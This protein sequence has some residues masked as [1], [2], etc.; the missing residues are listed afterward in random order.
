M[1]RNLR[2]GICGRDLALH[3]H[4][5]ANFVFPPVAVGRFLLVRIVIIDVR[6]LPIYLV[7]RGE[8]CGRTAVENL[9]PP[10]IHLDYCQVHLMINGRV[11]LL[12][13]RK[14]EIGL[15]LAISLNHPLLT[16]SLADALDLLLLDRQASQFR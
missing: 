12:H 4:E 15:D 6:F 13:Q 14:I 1:F 10:S 16:D 8:D 3:C 11:D 5:H 2:A 9:Q 7:L